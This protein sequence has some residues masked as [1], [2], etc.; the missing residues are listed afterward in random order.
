MTAVATVMATGMLPLNLWIYSRSW[1]DEPLVIPY[2]NILISFGLTIGPAL[3]GIFIRWK[4][5][6]VADVLVKV[7][8][9]SH[10]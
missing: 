2:L 8:L 6:R 10:C 4:F 1:T 9:V 3:V 7:K 5:P